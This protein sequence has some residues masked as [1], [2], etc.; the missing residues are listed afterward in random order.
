M[1]VWRSTNY[2]PSKGWSKHWCTILHEPVSFIFR[3]VLL[4]KT[5]NYTEMCAISATSL[6]LGGALIAIT[7]ELPARHHA[8]VNCRRKINAANTSMYDARRIRQTN[9]V[10]VVS[11][12]RPKFNYD[13]RHRNRV[14]AFK[15]NT[16]FKFISIH[17]FMML[18]LSVM[19]NYNRIIYIFFSY[20]AIFLNLK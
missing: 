13:H 8:L 6:S 12:N 11:T 14:A 19:S 5:F 2:W 18:K 4:H 9:F 17:D 15:F 7:K 3:S 10:F 20:F 1:T 16:S